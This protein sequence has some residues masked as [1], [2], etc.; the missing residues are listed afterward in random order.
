MKERSG[1]RSH[2]TQAKEYNKSSERSVLI[3]GLS[4]FLLRFIALFYPDIA[5]TGR[6][7]LVSAMLSFLLMLYNLKPK[8]DLDFLRLVSD[9][10]ADK[11]KFTYAF[12]MLAGLL[13]FIALI[14]SVLLIALSIDVS[15]A[16]LR[17][18]EIFLAISYLC[19]PSAAVLLP[20]L[21]AAARLM[22][23]AWRE[24]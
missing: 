14:V 23:E 16:A 1:S 9:R 20:R 2:V 19:M 22:I 11:D 21:I 4:Y 5:S 13:V 15:S 18:R 12:K 8:R 17:K 10:A 3:I 6:F 7:F 24:I